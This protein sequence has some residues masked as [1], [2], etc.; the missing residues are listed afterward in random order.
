MGAQ[1]M[2]NLSPLSTSEIAVTLT[3]PGPGVECKPSDYAKYFLYWEAGAWA[4]VGLSATIGKIKA[5]GCDTNVKKCIRIA[6]LESI[7]SRGEHSSRRGMCNKL[8]T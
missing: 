7:F 3:Y 6:L 8:S 5:I 1:L 2:K 4:V